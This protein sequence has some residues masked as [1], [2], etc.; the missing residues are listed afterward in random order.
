MNFL[1][2][3]QFI[4]VSLTVIIIFLMTIIQFIDVLNRDS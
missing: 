1:E 2:N 4:L 3:D